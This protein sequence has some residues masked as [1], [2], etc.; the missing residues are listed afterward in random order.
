MSDPIEEDK[1]FQD[2]KAR[3]FKGTIAISVV[4]GVIAIG[5]LVGMFFVPKVRDLL[6][7]KLFPFSITFVIGAILLIVFLIL[8]IV[9]YKPLP[10]KDD[11][12]NLILCPDYWE[13]TETPKKV[14]DK[15]P[16]SDRP[17]VKYSCIPQ[18]K[19][20]GNTTA[21]VN[22]SPDGSKVIPVLDSFNTG[23]LDIEVM[24]CNRIYPAYLAMKDKKDFPKKPNTLRCDLSSRCA[25]MPWTNVCP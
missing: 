9:M 16:E 18:T 14:I 22:T 10:K 5:I 21:A 2:N 11:L 6:G 20:Y 4:Y 19:V 23:K 7:D 8:Q 25:H 17:F 3:L 1:A 13:L 12:G 15:F 24:D